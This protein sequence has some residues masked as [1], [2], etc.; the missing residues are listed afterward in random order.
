VVVVV[1]VGSCGGARP[2]ASVIEKNGHLAI[3]KFP[4]KD[5]EI[6]AVLW[7]AVSLT[8]AKKAGI[9][10]PAG[11]VE[12]V[13]KKPVLLLRRFDRDGKRRIPLNIR[14]PRSRYAPDLRMRS[15]SVLDFIYCNSKH[16]TQKIAW[17]SE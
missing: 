3:A 12:T 16:I 8:L 13:A 11:R 6:N 15:C 4:R 5:D 17:R 9:E 2:K 10:V 1:S 14:L 7:E